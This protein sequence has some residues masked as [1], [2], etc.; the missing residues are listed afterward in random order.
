MYDDI[1]GNSPGYSVDFW[2]FKPFL[3][4]QHNPAGMSVR[5]HIKVRVKRTRKVPGFVQV[6]YSVSR[7]VGFRTIIWIFCYSFR[8]RSSFCGGRG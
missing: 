3:L 7:Y 8:R 4:T 6:S 5:V 1:L 2:S